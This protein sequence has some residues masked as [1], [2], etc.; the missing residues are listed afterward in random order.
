MCRITLRQHILL[1]QYCKLLDWR[2]YARSNTK[3]LPHVLNRMRSE[4]YYI[5]YKRKLKNKKRLCDIGITKGTM[6]THLFDSPM[7]DPAAY[8][9]RNTI[10][11]LRHCDSANIEVYKL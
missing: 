1:M 8:L 2:K 7:G 9:V 5:F 10:I 3:R 4:L 11:A 6:L